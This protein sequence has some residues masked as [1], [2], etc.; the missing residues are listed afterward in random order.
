MKTQPHIIY[1]AELLLIII[2]SL[3]PVVNPALAQV[4][5]SNSVPGEDWCIV[6][7]SA[8]GKVLVAVSNPGPIYISTNSGAAWSQAT[9]APVGDWQTVAC[10]AD[11]SK[12]IAAQGG[13]AGSL[14]GS[15]Y[16]SPDTGV[17]W[18]SNNAPELSWSTV[19]SSADGTKLVA[20]DYNNHGIYT[21]TDSGTTWTPAINSPKVALYSI[22][23]SADGS[24]L[25]AVAIK[26]SPYIYTSTDFGMAWITNNVPA[27]PQG[28][29]NGWGSIAS[30]ADGSKLIAAGGG[31][32]PGYIFL[33]TNFGAAWTV[34]ATN[35]LPSHGFD[36]WICVAS[37]A[38]GSKLAAVSQSTS[39]GE[40]ITST[41]SG[42]TWI[43]NPVPN[44]TW[45]AVAL[46]ADGAN[47]V[48]AVGYPS[49]VGPIYS[50][51]TIFAPVLNLASRSNNL[52]LSWIIP[53]TNFVL[54]QNS[55]LATTNW[56]TLTNAPALNLTDLQNQVMLSA[57]NSVGFYRLATP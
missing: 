38:D 17:T 4:W 50:S 46:S 29:Q 57:S 8:D 9:N 42:V 2:C 48:A 12:I 13:G 30:S 53:S 51:R 32:I 35:I 24:K 14:Y 15:I 23:S 33:S 1:R 55:D 40:I 3:F 52:A 18:V 6:A 41:D 37:S 43:T 28:I 10:S 27:S 56:V 19:A 47:R 31:G 7:S 16:T 25:A 44:L 34:T 39:P 54:Q 26:Y 11:G 21:S 45:N 20:A 36:E 5:S 22:S 49:Y